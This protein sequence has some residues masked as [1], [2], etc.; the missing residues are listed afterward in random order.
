[1]RSAFLVFCLATLSLS[2]GSSP[3]Y[4]QDSRAEKLR[5]GLHDTELG[6]TWIYDDLKAGFSQATRTGKPLLIVFR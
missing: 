5:R 4:A 1:M 2:I 6:G 3:L